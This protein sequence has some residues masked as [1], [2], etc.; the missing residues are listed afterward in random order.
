MEFGLGIGY[1]IVLARVFVVGAFDAGDSFTV[2][3]LVSSIE[4]I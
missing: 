4:C 1:G 2:L 3:S